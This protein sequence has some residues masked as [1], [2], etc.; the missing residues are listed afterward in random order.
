MPAT[1]RICAA[2]GASHG[3]TGVADCCAR[4]EVTPPTLVDRYCFFTPVGSLSASS[5]SHCRDA[6]RDRTSISIGSVG[7]PLA[8]VAYTAPIRALSMSSD[9]RISAGDTIASGVNWSPVRAR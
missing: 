8:F 3:N 6:A 1:W 7:M 9:A 5:H 2:R 4:L